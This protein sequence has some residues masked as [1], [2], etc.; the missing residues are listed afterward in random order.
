MLMTVMYGLDNKM[1]Q[2][3]PK[4]IHYATQGTAESGIVNS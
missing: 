4:A 1:V 3:I 2:D